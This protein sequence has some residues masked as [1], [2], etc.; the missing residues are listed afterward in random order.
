MGIYIQYIYNKNCGVIIVS[1]PVRG[2]SRATEFPCFPLLY[3]CLLWNEVLNNMPWN[4]CSP[5]FD[6]RAPRT[7]QIRKKSN[8]FSYFGFKLEKF[9]SDCFLYLT[10]TWIWV[11]GIAGKQDRPILIIEN[12]PQAPL[13][14][15]KC[16][17]F[18]TF[19]LIYEKLVFKLFP[20]VV[21]MSPL[22]W[23]LHLM[24]FRCPSR[25]PWNLCKG[26]N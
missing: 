2:R 10:C 25:Y 6:I 16:T 5:G 1:E 19:W 17:F 13:N 22:W 20:L 26:P 24:T 11:R 18:L 12:S 7:P 15:P 23:G 4:I 8:F 3:I 21:H 9:L 14:S